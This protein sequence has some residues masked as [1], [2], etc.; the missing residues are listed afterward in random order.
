MPVDALIDNPYESH[1][2]MTSEKDPTLMVNA[3]KS[4]RAHRNLPI[5]TAEA[6]PT[7]ATEK[8]RDAKRAAKAAGTEVKVK[9][10]PQKFQAFC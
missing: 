3:L 4:G 1:W 8:K 5:G 6:C 2:L 10:R 9:K 7:E